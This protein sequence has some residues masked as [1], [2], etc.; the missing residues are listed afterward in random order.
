VDEFVALGKQ[1]KEDNSEGRRQSPDSQSMVASGGTKRRRSS[2][3]SFSQKKCELRSSSLSA[4]LIPH[5]QCL[6]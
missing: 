3:D 4:T 1:W 5:H 6:K 2:E